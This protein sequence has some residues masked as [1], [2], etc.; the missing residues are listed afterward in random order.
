MLTVSTTRS[1]YHHG[2]LR[3]ALIEAAYELLQ[4]Q[5]A[6]QISLRSIA[7]QAGVSHA[8]PYNHFSD[9]TDLLVALATR[10]MASF[11][12][13]QATAVA[14]QTDAREQLLALGEAYVSY[15]ITHPNEFQLIFDPDISPPGSPP[16]GL[17]PVIENHTALLHGTVEAALHAGYL[18][19]GDPDAISA[20]LWSQVH[21][22]AHLILLGHLPA[23]A[24]GMILRALVTSGN[25]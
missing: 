20:A 1:P 6:Y 5:P 14:N 18:P 23:E 17:A 11:Y 12:E 22:L 9:R 8:A 19:H 4:H 16:L 21:G 25:E 3:E 15:A 24:A 10:C 7:R 13:T 2:Q